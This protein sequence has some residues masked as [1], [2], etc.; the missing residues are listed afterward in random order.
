M[1]ICNGCKLNGYILLQ[2][3]SLSL[4]SQKRTTKYD[5][6]LKFTN[7]RA[8]LLVV[9]CHSVLTHLE[10]RKLF[11]KYILNIYLFILKIIIN[12]K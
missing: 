1:N 7:L 12:W 10:A 4:L 11:C 6:I 9:L 3:T 5:N 2:L 8:K